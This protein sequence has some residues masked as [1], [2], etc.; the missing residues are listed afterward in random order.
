VPAP[1]AHSAP[2]PEREPHLY[3][4]HIHGAVGGALANARAV[5]VHMPDAKRAE[6]FVSTVVD[7]TTYHDLGKLDRDNQAALRRGRQGRM[8]WDHVDAGVARLMQARAETAAWIVRAHHA[9]GLP[10]KAVEFN[11]FDPNAR[12]LRG[13]RS[14][15][16]DA[17][18]ADA[19]T[20]RTDQTLADLVALHAAV[21]GAHEPAPG[22]ALHGLFMRL[23]SSC[24][25]DGDHADAARYESGRRTPDA[26]EPRWQ[27]RLAALDAYVGR[28]DKGAAR[29]ADRDAFYRACREGPVDKPMVAC[30]G[31]VGIGKTTAVAA[32]CLRRAI[33]SKARR[34]FIV[35]PYTTILSQT[36]RTLREALTLSDEAHRQDEI[37]AEHHHRADFQALDSRDLAVLWRAPTVVTTSVQFFETLSACGPARLRKLHGLPG[38]VVFLD[39]AHAILPAPLWRQSWTW[40]R[41][42]ADGWN[43]SFVFASGSLARLWEE[44]E[45]V[46]DDKDTRLPDLVPPA[47]STRLNKTEHGRVHFKTLHRIRDPIKA[48]LDTP[49]PRLAVFNTV[50]TAA[51]VADRMRKSGTDVLH[52]STALCPAD[53]DPILDEVKRR[54]DPKEGYGPDWT[55]VATSLVEA[56]VDLSFRTGLRER[57]SAASLIQIGGRVSRHGEWGSGEVI[58]F[59]LDADESMT[60]HPDAARPGAVLARLFEA[61]AFAQAIDPASLVTRSICEELRDAYGTTGVTLAEAERKRNYPEAARLGR[62]I[63]ADTRLVVV[64]ESLKAKLADRGTVSTKDLLAGSV[65]M[66]SSRIENLGIDLFPGRSDLYLWR[67]TYDPHFLGYMAGALELLSGTPL[68]L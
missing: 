21:A 48:V 2:D 11:R 5:A 50:Q 61:G 30:E 65:Q 16:R 8:C 49:G 17:D 4:D 33:H 67:R 53:R 36:A 55:L 52:L 18:K 45:I 40:I 19:L 12:G 3:A 35:A 43:C 51:V 56:G 1:L 20:A 23:A 13:G 14:A 29:R 41:E 27:E 58:D 15:D 68:F 34:L 63:D 32:W 62:L 22:A 26:P 28:L 44:P 25:V 42:L 47:L 59:L 38:S 7:G 37:V 39:E 6:R 24:L 54:L 31:P 9:P 10:A 66:W 46:G 64:D 57:F 60:T